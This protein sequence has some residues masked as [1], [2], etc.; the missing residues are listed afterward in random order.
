MPS[1]PN[2]TRQRL[3]GA[4]A[5][6]IGVAARASAGEEIQACTRIFGMLAKLLCTV[7]RLDG[8]DGERSA[9]RHG[10]GASAGYTRPTWPRHGGGIRRS[11]FSTAT[12]PGLDGIAES[13]FANVLCETVIMHL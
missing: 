3:A 6:E 4:V 8:R 2:P 13:C 10:L 7:I 1:V 11:I 12:L 9:T 5:R